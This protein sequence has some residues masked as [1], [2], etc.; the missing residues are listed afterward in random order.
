MI[1]APEAALEQVT[2]PGTE[3]ADRLGIRK[4]SS[5]K[6]WGNFGLQPR[7]ILYE[8][9]VPLTRGQKFCYRRIP[10]F[11][12]I[13]AVLFARPAPAASDAVAV[14]R[15]LDATLVAAASRQHD[16]F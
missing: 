16:F 11:L 1:C 15:Q 10:L 6:K 2:A 14:I 5:E 4:I 9:V 3:G 8:N 12:F 7:R 13:A